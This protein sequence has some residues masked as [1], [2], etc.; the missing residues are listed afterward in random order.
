M[1]VAL[2]VG[3]GGGDDDENCRDVRQFVHPVAQHRQRA[4]PTPGSE[5]QCSATSKEPEHD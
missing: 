4:G 1:E 3:Q 5:G 2:A